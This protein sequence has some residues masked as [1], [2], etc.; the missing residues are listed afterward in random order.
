M[1]AIPLMI[2]IGMVGLI[3]Q[4]GLFGYRGGKD[5][6][7]EDMGTDKPLGYFAF[8]LL[9]AALLGVLMTWPS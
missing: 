1:I 7:G 6:W 5:E 9:S 4:W 3:W 2:I 8:A